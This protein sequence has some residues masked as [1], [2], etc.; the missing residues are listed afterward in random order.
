ML[1][2]LGIT[3][4]L[5]FSLAACAGDG[6]REKAYDL[7]SK[8]ESVQVIAEEV[9]NDDSIPT[10]V[11][12]RVQEMENVA[13]EATMAYTR[14]VR[15][16]EGSPGD[17]LTEGLKATMNLVTYLI[18]HGYMTEGEVAHIFDPPYRAP[19]VPVRAALDGGSEFAT[20]AGGV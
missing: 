4:A 14:A 3:I 20:Q 16:G 12:K 8:L 18:E 11:R 17:L 5:A 6:P 19:P 2:R 15:E 9:V 7:L 13:Y 1:R 10:D